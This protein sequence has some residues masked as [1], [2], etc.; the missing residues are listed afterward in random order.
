MKPAGKASVRII[1]LGGMKPDEVKAVLDK[2]I[3]G[4]QPGRQP[5]GGGRRPQGR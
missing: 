4:Q 1:N 5:G 3:Q 2:L